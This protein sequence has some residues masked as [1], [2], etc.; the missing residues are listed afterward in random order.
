MAWVSPH[1]RVSPHPPMGALRRRGG[2][3]VKATVLIRGGLSGCRFGDAG[4]G[5][6]GAGGGHGNVAARLAGVSRGRSTSWDLRLCGRGWE[7]LNVMSR[8][9]NG[10]DW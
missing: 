7:G 4:C 6:V 8:S 10:V 5:R 1:A 2:D 3:R 9:V